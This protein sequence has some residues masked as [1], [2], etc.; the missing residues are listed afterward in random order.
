MVEDGH[1][2]TWDFTDVDGADAVM[3]RMRMRGRTRHTGIDVDIS[4]TSVNWL[5]GGRI[6]RSAAYTER[7]DAL[8]AAGPNPTP[9]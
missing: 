9:E 5:R 3:F 1:F 6:Y 2:E 4:W 7:A 8:E